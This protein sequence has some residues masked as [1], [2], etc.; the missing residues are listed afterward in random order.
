MSKNLVINGP[1]L[2]LLGT[3]QP[4]IYGTVT[5]GEIQNRLEEL[6]KELGVSVEFFQSNHEGGI[7]D[8][9]HEAMGVFDGIIINPGG[10]THYSYAIRDAFSSVNI[11]FVEVHLSNIHARESF[12]I[13][14]LADVAIGQI[15]GF[16]ALGYEL[17]LQA[18]V[19]HKK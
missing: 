11:P 10:Y 15:A 17:A 5:L 13:S 19:R 7:I 14:V 8:C 6:A 12:R 18:I 1:N 9:I 4:D 3:R 16:G 2:N